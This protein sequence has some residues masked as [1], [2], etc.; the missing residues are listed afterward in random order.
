MVQEYERAVIFRL[1]RLLPGG[2]RGPGMYSTVYIKVPLNQSNPYRFYCS[3]L[4]FPASFFRLLLRFF[5][6]F[7][8][9]I[10]FTVSPTTRRIVFYL[11]L[12]TFN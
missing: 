1:G 10:I 5:A 11:T 3:I 4:N 12:I 9:S 6:T 7:S 8:H 2:A